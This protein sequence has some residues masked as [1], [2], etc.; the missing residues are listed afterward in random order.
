MEQV[1]DNKCSIPESDMTDFSKA[2]NEFSKY[3]QMETAMY[4]SLNFMCESK[5]KNND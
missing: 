1:N 2:I 5:N 4:V 3:I